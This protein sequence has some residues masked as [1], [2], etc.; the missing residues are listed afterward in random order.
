MR[1]EL[2]KRSERYGMG[3]TKG[4]LFPMMEALIGKVRAVLIRR[5]VT[6]GL[7]RKANDK[8]NDSDRPGLPHGGKKG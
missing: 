7:W 6:T 2:P 5:H 4:S 1:S 8:I 3:S